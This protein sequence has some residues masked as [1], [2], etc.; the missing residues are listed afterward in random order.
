MCSKEA[1]AQK[2]VLEITERIERLQHLDFN[3][4]LNL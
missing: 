3:N 1:Q 2:D 4:S